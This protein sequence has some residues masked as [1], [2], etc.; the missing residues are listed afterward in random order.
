MSGFRVER[1]KTG[2][3][4]RAEDGNAIFQRMTRNIGIKL[5]GG[6]PVTRA[7]AGDRQLP[8]QIG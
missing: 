2:R 5:R 3:R 7:V 6:I 1:R 8:I 4:Y